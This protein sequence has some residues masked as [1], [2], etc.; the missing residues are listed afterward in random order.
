[1]QCAMQYAGVEKEM[2]ADYDHTVGHVFHRGG[3][4]ET[5]K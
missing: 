5:N 4:S 2:A 3:Q 1:M